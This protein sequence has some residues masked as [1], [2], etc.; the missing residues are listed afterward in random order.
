MQH[1]ENMIDWEKTAK[2]HS[3]TIEE[4]Q[5]YFNK[6][7]QSRKDVVGVC[8]GC[9]RIKITN[10]QSYHDR[11]NKCAK[12]LPEARK[13]AS[14][15]SIEQWKIPEIRDKMIVNISKGVSG[16]FYNN[17]VAKKRA[18]AITTQYFIDHPEA[19]EAARLKTIAQMS[20]PQTRIE[21]GIK[22]IQYYKDHPEAREA[23]KSKTLD[24][25]SDPTAIEKHANIT[26]EYY[27]NNPDAGERHSA[28]M[29]GQDY[30]A[31]EWTGHTDKSRPHV[32]P[33]NQCIHINDRFIGSEGHHILKDVVVF[34]P[35]E[36]HE[37]VAHNIKTGENMGEIN[38]LAI[39]F[40]NGGLEL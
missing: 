39:Q 34:I 28:F 11:C 12:R 6:Y 36:L 22:S 18:S 19:R 29:Q 26:L 31:G 35:S 17:H 25:F 14:L 20:D 40:I 7:Q 30:D 9:G 2:M 27:K 16:Y 37:H 3:M 21:I 24:Q 23:A 1:G 8:D 15:K 32:I 38:A 13:A 10:R 5:I 33:I 4:S